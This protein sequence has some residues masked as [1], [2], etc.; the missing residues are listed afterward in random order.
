MQS[1]LTDMRSGET[2]VSTTSTW[3]HTTAQGMPDGLHF[4]GSLLAA[5]TAHGRGSNNCAQELRGYSG[6][7]KGLRRPAC[8]LHSCLCIAR[9][10]RHCS[11]RG[12]EGDRHTPTHCGRGAHTAW[13][14]RSHEALPEGDRHTPAGLCAMCNSAL[15]RAPVFSLPS[16]V[17][18]V[19]RH[20]SLLQQ[21]GSIVAL[22]PATS[23]QH[24]VQK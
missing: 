22:S 21:L 16:S 11:R 13:R 6:E 18:A 15:L 20:T 14:T 9:C 24:Q 7:Q 4:F 17:R 12:R 3:A 1:K 5:E 10:T 2:T 8:C 19:Q 23:L